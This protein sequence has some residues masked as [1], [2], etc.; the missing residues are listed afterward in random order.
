MNHP[1]SRRVNYSPH[2]TVHQ[3]PTKAQCFAAYCNRV[4][5][6]LKT[7]KCAGETDNTLWVVSR[8]QEIYN[9]KK[10]QLRTAHSRQEALAI[11]ID[12]IKED[13]QRSR[14]VVDELNN[15]ETRQEE[16]QAALSTADKLAD[17]VRWLKC[18]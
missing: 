14:V 1:Y 8:H 9:R 15:D 12:E 10:S 18:N 17:V 5:L 3:V 6:D 4:P 13:E 2:I 11:V 7:F 16:Y